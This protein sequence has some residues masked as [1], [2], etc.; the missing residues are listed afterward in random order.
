MGLFTLLL[1]GAGWN[2]HDFVLEPQNFL[3]RA[4]SATC[5]R[6]VYV[7]RSTKKSCGIRSVQCGICGREES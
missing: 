6:S 7:F 4:D 1:A 5:Y 3:V 2:V